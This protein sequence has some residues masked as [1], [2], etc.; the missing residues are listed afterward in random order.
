M[1]KGGSVTLAR[2]PALT[3]CRSKE[4]ASVPNSPGLGW[5]YFS[6][7]LLT[8]ATLFGC[9]SAFSACCARIRNCLRSASKLAF[10]V[11]SFATAALTAHFCASCRSCSERVVIQGRGLLLCGDRFLGRTK[12]SGET[13]PHPAL[14]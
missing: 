14:Q 8:C 6:L 12:K 9:R 1:P 11:G 10:V 2:C 4:T 7:G 13:R 3:L 5:G